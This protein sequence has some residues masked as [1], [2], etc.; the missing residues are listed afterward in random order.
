MRKIGLVMGL[1]MAIP[2]TGR[3]QVNFL[4]GATSATAVVEISRMSS[5][6]HW[7]ERASDGA[8]H[9]KLAEVASSVLRQGGL[10]ELSASDPLGIAIVHWSVD[11]R[12]LTTADSVRVS[13]RLN[14]R[15]WLQLPGAKVDF[16]WLWVPLGSTEVMS[17]DE[18][19]TWTTDMV[20][21]ATG[22]LVAGREH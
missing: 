3:A 5:E 6:G 4:A 14:V 1:A 2:A 11:I 10:P 21:L 13:L 17:R 18:V 15:R 12:E 22:I 20:K 9:T 7:V 16:Y 19:S 8:L